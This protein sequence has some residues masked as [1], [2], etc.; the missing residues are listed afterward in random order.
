MDKLRKDDADSFKRLI[1]EKENRK[2][3]ALAENKRAEWFGL[4]MFGMIGWSV[5]VPTFLG[6]IGGIWL[7]KNYPQS[8]SWTLTCLISGLLAGCLIAWNW[9]IKQD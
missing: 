2:L 1:S 7:D 9:V 5:A 4:G 3:K 6:T 8:F